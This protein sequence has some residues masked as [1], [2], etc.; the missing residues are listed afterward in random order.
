MQIDLEKNIHVFYCHFFSLSIII[1]FFPTRLRKQL[2]FWFKVQ[3]LL[4]VNLYAQAH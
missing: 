2:T 3:G 4:W 1:C